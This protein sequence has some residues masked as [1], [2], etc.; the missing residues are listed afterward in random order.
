MKNRKFLFLPLI[1]SFAVLTLGVF[2]F[3]LS[4]YF[5]LREEGDALFRVLWETLPALIVL[6][7]LG[8]FCLV[9]F[10]L[11]FVKPLKKMRALSEKIAE[12]VASGGE[13]PDAVGTGCIGKLSDTLVSE[14]EE[15]S[16]LLASVIKET[17]EKATER[18]SRAAARAICAE[19]AP[20]KLQLDALTYGV[21]TSIL[22]SPAVGA[23]FCDAF[24]IDGR[25]VFVAV[26]DVWEQGLPAALLTARLV[27]ALREKIAEG[28]T[29][30][31][32]LS[33]LNESLIADGSGAATLFCAI[34]D[35]VSGELRFANAGHFPPVIAGEPCG[36]L[37]MRPATPL[38]L[39][40][41]AEFTDETFGLHPGQGIV[42]YTEG[43]VNTSNGK[44]IFG[45]GR[46]LSE[47]GKYYANALETE[48]VAEGVV[49]AVA[50]FAQPE[51]D[52]AAL[53][54]FFP[55]GAQKLLQ[56]DLSE[57]EKMRELL[58]HWL[59]DDPRK[60][61]IQLACEEIFKN[62]VEHAGAKSIRI[63]CEREDESL[64]IRFTD[65]G[66]PFNPLQTEGGTF[67][68]GEGGVGMTIIRRIAGEIFYRTKQNLN[69]LTVR[70]PVIKGI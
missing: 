66:E 12:R 8:L 48:L 30:A 24:A 61:N 23:D 25:R 64:I 3:G 67:P 32:A 34:L 51:E 29:P 10:L 1:L 11:F 45:Y 70:F 65:D 47:V 46:L 68:Y 40:A 63:G 14:E 5:V 2:L 52:C 36:F 38:G 7:A 33:S 49:N 59:R 13:K 28:F 42:A 18:A 54:L 57:T 53:A 20:E 58:D 37:R 50:E 19:V 35:S 9:Y 62:I 39:Y 31:Q 4:R 44:E 69:V 56:A 27:R 43:V 15:L 26:G 60:K 21:R 6:A 41:D 16:A 22:R 55:A 17:D